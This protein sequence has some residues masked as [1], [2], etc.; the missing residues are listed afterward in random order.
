VGILFVY[1]T[2]QG[3]PEKIASPFGGGGEFSYG[4]AIKSA[5]DTGAERPHQSST[6]SHHNHH[7]TS[8]MPQHGASATVH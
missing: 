1:R 8:V 6:C 3:A 2:F 4:I 5:H 7:V